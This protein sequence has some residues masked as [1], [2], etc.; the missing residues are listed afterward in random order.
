MTTPPPLGWGNVMRRKRP[1]RQLSTAGCRESTTLAEVTVPSLSDEPE[2]LKFTVRA[3]NPS[4]VEA[5]MRATGAEL[6]G[7]GGGVLS[8]PPPVFRRETLDDAAEG[9]SSRNWSCD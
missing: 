7:A 9:P 4:V 8:P 1:T 5:E 2:P 6:T 3:A